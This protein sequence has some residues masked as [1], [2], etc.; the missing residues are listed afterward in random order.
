MARRSPTP[1]RFADDVAARLA[2][3]ASSRAGLSIS[4]AANLLVDEGLRMAEHPGVVFRDGPSG[5][6]AGCANGPDVWEVLRAVRSARHENPAITDDEVLE[7]VA[8]NS[9]LPMRQVRT[10]LTYWA[11]YPEEVDS[12]VLLADEADQAAEA[13]WQRQRQLLAGGA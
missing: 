8:A 10:A 2:A 5:R 1:V 6:R 11:S 7:L 12:D 9:G 3:F 13:A 4:G